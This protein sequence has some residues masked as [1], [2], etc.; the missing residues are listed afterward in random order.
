MMTSAFS[1]TAASKSPLAALASRLWGPLQRE[2]DVLPGGFRPALL[3][4]LVAAFA[5]RFGIGWWLPNINQADEVYQVAEQASRSVKGYGIATWEFRTSSRTVILPTLVSP[6]YRL[7]V[8]AATHR[9]LQT[10]LFCAL[11]LIP[12]WVAFQWAARLYGLRG[13]V[14]AAIMMATWFELVY[15]APKAAADIVCSYCLLLAVFLSRP[16]ARRRASFAAGVA[17]IVALAIRVQVAPA[18]GFLLLIALLAGGRARTMALLGGAAVGLAVTGAIEWSWWGTPFQG[19]VGYLVMEFTHRS[20]RFFGRQPFTYYLKQYVLM[21]GAALPMVWVLIGSG[22]RTAP[23]LLLAALSVIVPFHFVG[24]KEYRFV[25]AGLPLLVLLMGLAAAKWTTSLDPEKRAAT[26]PLLI[27]GWLIAMTAVSLGDT[28]RPLWTRHGNHVLA[29]EEI[30]AQAD[31]CGVALV[32][33]R[34]WQTP[35]SSGLGRDIPIYEIG[36]DGDAARLRA[37]ANYV[38]QATKAEPPLP[39]YER[40]REYTRPVQ[41]VYRRP[42]GCVPDEAARIARPPGI[43]GVE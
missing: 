20:S 11:S 24:H 33:I 2:P 30:G 38:L 5:L 19:Q 7:D 36:S 14:L 40:W 32:G 23:V 18:V 39:P 12:V 10:G 37:A 29:F 34:W 26:L 4:V 43:P 9:F 41:Y 22:A 13:A 31:A 28:Y 1:E 16:G 6:I 15:F 21:Y 42:G 17:F 35:G 27:V 3:A 8:P 25:V